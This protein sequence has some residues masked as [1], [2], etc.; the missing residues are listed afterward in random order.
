MVAAMTAHRRRGTPESG[1]PA[2]ELMREVAAAA[3]SGYVA[4]QTAAYRAHHLLAR[5]ALAVTSEGDRVF[6]GG[7]SAGYLAR[8]LVAAGRS[9]DGA[10]LDPVE[11]SKAA[12]VCDQVLV[13]DLAELDLSVLRDDYRLLMFGDTLE[14]LARPEEVLAELRDHLREDGHLIVSVPNI[15]NWSVRLLLLAGR[16]RYTDRGILDRTHLRFYTVATLPEMLAAAGFE[17][18]RMQASVPVPGISGPRLAELAYRI[19]NVRPGLFGY[20]LL[21]TCVKR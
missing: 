15:A 16:F 17:V 7:V 11:A 20:N 3:P 12:E 10:E 8:V 19:G 21:A 2:L 1:D 9:V 13:G 4:L 14:H 5:E 18:L 6:E